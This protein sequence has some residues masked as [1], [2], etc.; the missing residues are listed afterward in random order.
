[1]TSTVTL[2]DIDVDV[3]LK[4]IRNLHLSVHPPTG[5]VRISAPIEMKDE[6]IRAFAISKLDWI[7]EQQRVLNAQEREG[8]REYLERESHYVW[9]KRYL[10]KVVERAGPPSV[11][12]AHNQ[13]ILRI[14]PGVDEVIRASVVEDW[15]RELVKAAAPPLIDLWGRRLGVV[16]ERFYVRH[17]KTMWGSCNH[18]ARTIRLNTE[19]AKKPK[20]CLEY[21]IVHELAHLLE[22]THNARFIG[23]IDRFMPHWQHR[24]EVLNRF[25]VRHETWRY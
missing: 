10:L 5:R 24:R 7:K 19:L 25:P 11:E 3:V 23:L 15:Y 18:K 22:P 4:D 1:M 9:G 17:M 8:P 2:G 20:E 16:P 13:L 21:I 6:A 12:L 14:R